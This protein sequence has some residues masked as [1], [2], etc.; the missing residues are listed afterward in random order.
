MKKLSLILLTGLI[1]ITG[2]SNTSDTHDHSEHSHATTKEVKG[3]SFEVPELEED[4]IVLAELDPSI[5]YHNKE[6]WVGKYKTDEGEFSLEL[7]LDE[8]NPENKS[9]LSIFN[10]DTQKG[11]AQILSI[12]PETDF[13]KIALT[14]KYYVVVESEKGYEE[15]TDDYIILVPDEKSATQEFFEKDSENEFKANLDGYRLEHSSLYGVT[16]LTL[17]FTEEQVPLEEIL[18]NN[19]LIKQN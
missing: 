11:K 1:L 13:G 4:T 19:I 3:E 12:Q 14:V 15:A 7:T 2:C 16:T 5:E 9:D 6:F 17:M 8:L 10:D 18:S